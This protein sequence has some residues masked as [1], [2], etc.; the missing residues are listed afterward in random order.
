VIKYDSLPQLLTVKEAAECFRVSRQYIYTL[1]E[2][3]RLPFVVVGNVRRIPADVIRDMASVGSV[4][5]ET[6]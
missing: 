6:A 3:G 1:M 5:S 2:S 4:A